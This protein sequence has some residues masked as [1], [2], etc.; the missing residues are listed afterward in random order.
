MSCFD[1][2]VSLF[3]FFLRLLAKVSITWQRPNA[4]EQNQEKI[5]RP[6]FFNSEIVRKLAFSTAEAENPWAL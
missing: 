4:S 1:L 6:F 2:S 5:E 3:S